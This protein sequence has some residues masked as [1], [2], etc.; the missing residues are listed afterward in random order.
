MIIWII[1]LLVL[2]FMAWTGYAQGAISALVSLVGLI[3]AIVSAAP[4]GRLIQPLFSL[5]GLANPYWLWILPPTVAFVLVLLVFAGISFAAH[6]KVRLY[7]KHKAD[8]YERMRWERLNARA[9]LAVGLGSG[10]VYVLLLAA[11]VYVAGYA[12]VQ[13]SNDNSPMPLQV[14]N[15][16]RKDLVSS[17]LDKTA[18]K[19]DPASNLFY[20]ASDILGLVYHN[21]LLH[22]RLADYPAFL[23]FGERPEFQEIATDTEFNQMLQSQESVTKILNHPKI[24]AVVKN[25]EIMQSV[26]SVAPHDLKQYLTTGHSAQYGEEKILGRWE[27]TLSATLSALQRGATNFPGLSWINLRNTSTPVLAGTTFKFTAENKVYMKVQVKEAPAAASAPAPGS[28]P[29]GGSQPRPGPAPTPRS[30]TA[31]IVPSVDSDVE[32]SQRRMRQRYGAAYQ[33]AAPPPVVLPA[34]PPPRPPPQ[35]P[36]TKLATG[37]GTWQRKDEVYAVSLTIPGSSQA[38]FATVKEDRLVLMAGPITFVCD[39]MY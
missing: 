5:V 25:A 21:P 22:S 8:D 1:A 38:A 30:L 29:S 33:Q 9:G 37:E 16:A 35:N 34:A 12:S 14:L 39:R 2:A 4:L 20:E 19:F 28:G 10:C 15:A 27:V 32:Q 3:V 17:G 31:G 26:S 6:W 24:Q 18:A 36:L 23:G 13:L 11:I 7:Y